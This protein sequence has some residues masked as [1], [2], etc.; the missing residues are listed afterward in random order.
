MS[1]F[2]NH[3]YNKEK[4]KFDKFKKECLASIDNPD[5]AKKPK[6]IKITKKDQKKLL[7]NL[8][9]SDT[10]LET[11]L[12]NKKK[13]TIS[14][15]GLMS[16]D[17]L[18]KS[19]LLRL[20]ERIK[21]YKKKKKDEENARLKKETE[22]CEKNAKIEREKNEAAKRNQIYCDYH[23][24][25]KIINNSLDFCPVCNSSLIKE[26]GKYEAKITG[27]FDK[28]VG[29]TSGY[30]EARPQYVYELMERA[31]PATSCKCPQCEYTVMSAR[32]MYF[33][34]YLTRTVDMTDTDSIEYRKTKKKN[35]L[36]MYNYRSVYTTVKGLITGK[37]YGDNLQELASLSLPYLVEK[38]YM[39][40]DAFY[41]KKPVK[42]LEPT[43]TVSPLS[44]ADEIAKFYDL[45]EK[46]IISED[47]FEKKKK[48]LLSK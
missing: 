21:S 16:F 8:L 4:K 46:G 33:E 27:L 29:Y 13:K 39:N 44:M 35:I 22:L 14:E 25:Q 43:V 40:T 1:L 47:E 19:D 3:K 26:N 7:E 42:K 23:T 31:F 32:Y 24:M 10:A 20:D 41:E 28:L 34:K 11:Y 17:L 5:S 48:E 6:A 38:V 2:G 30:V 45:K 37:L 12:T 9:V 18:E 36:E 15:S